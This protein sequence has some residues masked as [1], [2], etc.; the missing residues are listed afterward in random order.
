MPFPIQR[1]TAKPSRFAPQAPTSGGTG[2][3]SAIT[4]PVLKA[5]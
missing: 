2:L 3:E 1:P 4:L 5:T